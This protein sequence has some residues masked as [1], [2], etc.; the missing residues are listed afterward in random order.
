VPC[1]RP[2]ILH[3]PRCTGMLTWTG[4]KTHGPV[5]QAIKSGKERRAA[6]LGSH[7]LTHTHKGERNRSRSVSTVARP[8]SRRH[9]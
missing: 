3:L 7:A 9:R 6:A 8:V 4:V 5:K 1:H 2:H